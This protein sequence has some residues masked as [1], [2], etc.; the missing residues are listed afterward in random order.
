MMTRWK[1]PVLGG[2][3]M[4]TSELMAPALSPQSV[5]R[6]GS[7]PNAATLSTTQRMAA[8]WSNKPK[9]PRA[10][11]AALVTSQPSASSR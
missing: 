5:T 6:D 4:C 1:S 3:L 8:R 9:L 2:E 7:P 10:P 11:F